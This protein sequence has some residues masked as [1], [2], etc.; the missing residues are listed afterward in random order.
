M[1]TGEIIVL[2]Y[3]ILAVIYCVPT[4]VAFSR[5]HPNRW[6]ICVINMAFGGTV[7]GWFGTLIWALSAVH[8]SPTGSNGG[9][10]GLNLFV[11]DP[12]SVRVLPSSADQ[13]LVDVGDVSLT[14]Q[15]LKALKE[16]NVISPEECEN[17]RRELVRR[18]ADA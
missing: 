7:I 1:E 3:L 9:E 13:R 18:H 16:Q 11:N 14:L 12:V 5:R 10:S 6:L 2:G 8:K 17:L 15:R 4:F